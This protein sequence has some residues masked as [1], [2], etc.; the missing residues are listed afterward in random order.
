MDRREGLYRVEEY[1][2]V[3]FKEISKREDLFTVDE[4]RRIDKVFSLIIVDPYLNIQSMHNSLKG[5]IFTYLIITDPERVKEVTKS[6]PDRRRHT[7]HIDREIA[8]I[9]NNSTLYTR[10]TES[11]K[12]HKPAEHNTSHTADTSHTP[13]T[14]KIE[15]RKNEWVINRVKEYAMENDCF[16]S[17]NKSIYFILLDGSASFLPFCMP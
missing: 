7:L 2:D 11:T 4:I 12:R 13:H 17:A 15:R 5:T 6:P 3:L 8:R 10:G 9:R 16:F 1:S 14:Y